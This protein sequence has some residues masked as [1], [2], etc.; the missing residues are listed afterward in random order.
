MT[1]P[2]IGMLGAAR[3]FGRW[4]LDL[5]MA[6]MVYNRK[7]KV[8]LSVIALFFFLACSASAQVR[9]IDPDDVRVV[10]A[11]LPVFAAEARNYGDEIRVWRILMSRER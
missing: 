6:G 11:P 8:N 9:V 4:T 1:G 7:M 3:C 10:S 5:G 2:S